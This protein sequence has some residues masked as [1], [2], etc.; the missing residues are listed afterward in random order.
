MPFRG[1]RQALDN[2]A[3]EVEGIGDRIL[4]YSDHL[5]PVIYGVGYAV[6]S[7]KCSKINDLT[8]LP[9]DSSQL[10]YIRKR[11]D[12]TVIRPSHDQPIMGICRT[13]K[14]ETATRKERQFGHNTVL[15]FERGRD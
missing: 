14:A 8:S 15:P 1:R 5:A 4:C 13:S 7:A 6:T 2:R 10:R 3:S 9:D 12:Q 11:I